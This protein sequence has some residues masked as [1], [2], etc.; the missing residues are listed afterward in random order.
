MFRSRHQLR[1][2]AAYVLLAWLFGVGAGTINACLAAP[3]GVSRVAPTVDAQPHYAN[4]L[5]HAARSHEVDGSAHH[6]DEVPSP[7]KSNCRD[8]CD[9]SSTAATPGKIDQHDDGPAHA[10]S[11]TWPSAVTL[12]SSDASLDLAPLSPRR[13]GARPPP[14]RIAFVRLAL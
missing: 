4:D 6:H 14:I 3:A 7:A 11:A 1:R 9:K 5:H 10:L 2:W 13:S 12:M 8:F